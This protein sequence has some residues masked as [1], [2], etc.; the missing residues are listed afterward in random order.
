MR[1]YQQLAEQCDAWFRYIR[2][3]S[4][5]VVA[6]WLLQQRWADSWQSIPPAMVTCQAVTQIFASHVCLMVLPALGTRALVEWLWL[7]A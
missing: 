5:C 2:C 7:A 3:I 1:W 6:A 4:S